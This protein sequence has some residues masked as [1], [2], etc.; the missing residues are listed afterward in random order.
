MKACQ[1]QA[2]TEHFSAPAWDA[3]DKAQ[4]DD[5]YDHGSLLLATQGSNQPQWH[6]GITRDCYP[7]MGW[8]EVHR[9]MNN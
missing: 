9:R 4:H 2:G 3:E 5:Q 1:Q 7:K 8:L 6:Q